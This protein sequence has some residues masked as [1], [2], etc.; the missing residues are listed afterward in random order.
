[1]T[2]FSV[3]SSMSF[4]KCVPLVTTPGQG[5]DHFHQPRGSSVAPFTVNA[6]SPLASTATNELA[7][8]KG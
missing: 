8:T 5:M 3:F 7:V 2:S 6:P 1:M 4:D